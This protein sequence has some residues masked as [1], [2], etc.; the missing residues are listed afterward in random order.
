MPQRI[1]WSVYFAILAL[2]LFAWFQFGGMSVDPKDR[3][4]MLGTWTDEAGPPGN[5]IRFYLV[6]YDLPGVPLTKAYE[7]HATLVKHLGEENA[8]GGW[9]YGSWDP[10]VL[11]F[12]VG[13]KSWYVAIRKLDDD[14]ILIRFGTDAE[15]L[16]R[17]EALDH[18]D[19]RRLTRIGREESP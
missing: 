10:L 3:D 12:L 8:K 16:Y 13:K 2:A 5:S 17:S 19:T 9:N 18:P 11:N 4:I 6:A 7:G 15:E 1:N 14:H